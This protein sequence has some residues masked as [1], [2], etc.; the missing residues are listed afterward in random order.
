MVKDF[1]SQFSTFC[2]HA[3]ILSLLIKY[4]VYLLL[5]NKREWLS[6]LPSRGKRCRVL[7]AGII[8]FYTYRLYEKTNLENISYNGKTILM[9]EI[10]TQISVI[11][12]ADF[13]FFHHISKIL[14][15]KCQKIFYIKIL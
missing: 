10:I 13:N 5:S 6:Q 7:Y 9:Y 2:P 8:I 1:F 3:K 4:P 12:N 15:Q 11:D 14:Q